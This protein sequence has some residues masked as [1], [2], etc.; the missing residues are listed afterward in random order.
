MTF[1]LK[2][3][4]T[5]QTMTS[6]KALQNLKKICEEDLKDHY[7]LEVIDVIQ[8]PELAEK[9]KILVTPAL[10]KELPPPLS[11]MIGDLSNKEDVLLGIN[12][13]NT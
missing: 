5:G 4:I 7:E 11:L 10:L 6:A 9:D 12:I 8:H 3:F 2:L 1:K 13:V